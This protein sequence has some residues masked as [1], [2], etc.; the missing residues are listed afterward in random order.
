LTF[1]HIF[2]KN[3]SNVWFLEGFILWNIVNK[4]YSRGWF[5][6]LSLDEFS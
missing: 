1:P 2:R 6:C 3:A 4:I 5:G